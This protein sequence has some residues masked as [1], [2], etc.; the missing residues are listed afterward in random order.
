MRVFLP[1]LACSMLLACAPVR[2]NDDDSACTTG[3]RV[4][5]TMGDAP[6]AG[7]AF[8]RAGS[9]DTA[10]LESP[11]GDDGCVTFSPAAGSWEWRASDDSTNPRGS[12]IA[13]VQ[14][15]CGQA[16]VLPHRWGERSYPTV[17]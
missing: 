17:R 7:S 13:A 1:I 5:A 12:D 16:T 14:G 8:L 15:Q 2:S 10:P 11:L 9:D 3:L 4:C 6:S